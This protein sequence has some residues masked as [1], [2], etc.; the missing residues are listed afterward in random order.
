MSSEP[1][2]INLRHFTNSNGE[3]GSI[4]DSSGAGEGREVL[5]QPLQLT[6]IKNFMTPCRKPARLRCS[7][8]CHAL[9]DALEAL[10]PS[11]EPVLDSRL[12]ISLA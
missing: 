8:G 1:T 2:A 7:G 4:S 12:F 5:G 6:A 3:E 11:K 10:L 9:E